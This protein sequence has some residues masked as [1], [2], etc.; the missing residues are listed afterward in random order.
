MVRT[1]P[2]ALAAA[3]PGASVA[4]L[5]SLRLQPGN[6]GVL[7]P[8]GLSLFFHSLN[9]TFLQL[10]QDHGSL[11]PLHPVPNTI[12]FYDTVR[13]IKGPRRERPQGSTH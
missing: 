9:V 7:E 5:T 6:L 4:S 2:W 8:T 10:P 3:F 11:S 13:V 12:W 1:W